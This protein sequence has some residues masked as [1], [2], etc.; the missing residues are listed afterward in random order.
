[1]FRKVVTRILGSVCVAAAA[2]LPLAAEA[3]SA[4]AGASQGDVALATA[5][6]ALSD[7]SGRWEGRFR[8]YGARRAACTGEDCNKLTLDVARCGETWCGVVV[9]KDGGCG[10]TALRAAGP[11]AAEAD[12]LAF[13]GT[14]KLAEGTEPYTVRVSGQAKLDDEPTTLWVIGDTGGELRLFRRSFPFEARLTRQGEPTCKGEAKT[15]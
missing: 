13:E 9:D 10:V 8:A 2:A 15:S 5:P 6:T 1:M 3:G 12:E 7:I 14:L 4:D 11:K